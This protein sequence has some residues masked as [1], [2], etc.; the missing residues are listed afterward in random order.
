[1]QKLLKKKNRGFT[2]VELMVVIAIIAVLAGII[3]PTAMKGIDK[4]KVSRAIADV[5]AV[6]AAAVEYY[7]DNG[8]W[9][10]DTNDFTS[11]DGNDPYIDKWPKD[12]WKNSD[13]GWDNANKTITVNNV[14]D[15]A[16][17][18][19][20]EALGGNYSNGSYTVNVQ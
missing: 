13:F 19:M 6:K 9:P 1:M 15:S 10:T 8:S 12:P 2:L 5:K 7:A 4:S 3:I 16:K 20:N 18:K 17:D 11:A 14:P